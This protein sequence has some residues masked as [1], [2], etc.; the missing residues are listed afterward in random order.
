MTEY[1]DGEYR[2]KS[3]SQKKR[4]STAVQKLGQSLAALAKGDLQ[5]LDLPADLYEAL[6]E[7]KSYRSHEAKRR[8]MQYIGRI[9]RD[10][11]LAAIEGPPRAEPGGNPGAARNRK[12]ARSAGHRFGY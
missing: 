5:S 7:W 4:E 1:F 2:D 12:F 3:R 9:M 10:M 8:Q 11:D 6:L